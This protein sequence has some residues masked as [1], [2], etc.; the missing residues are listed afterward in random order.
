MIE[1]VIERVTEAQLRQDIIDVARLFTSR[2]L[3]VGKSGNVSVR[4]KAGCL[5]TPSALPYEQLET[6][7]IVQLDLQGN[8]SNERQSPSSEWHFHCGIY[9]NR[10]DVKAIIH[11]HSTYCTALACTH[12]N[13]PAFH[14]MVAVVGGRDIPLVPYALFGT[15]ALSNHVVEG[16]TNRNACLLANHGAVI[17]GGDLQGT[18]SLAEEVENLAQQYC[19]V[20][21]VGE[22]AILG[23][24]EMDE[25]LEK[26]K[27]YGKRVE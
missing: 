6:D 16:L 9:K 8:V 7:D 17:V 10:N 21:K 24:N 15:K 2:G 27:S 4:Y 1:R 5:I 18:F 12:K 13:I 3:S 20:L 19:E 11:M 26:F 23:D 14:Y 25:V 22:P